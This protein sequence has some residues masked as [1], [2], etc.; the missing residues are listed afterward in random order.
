MV[1]QRAFERLLVINIHV[2]D[3]VRRA[4]EFVA[5]LHRPCRLGSSGTPRRGD[6][7]HACG[8]V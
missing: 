6:E 3:D 4:R 2:Y 8:W 7:P 5:D 1:L